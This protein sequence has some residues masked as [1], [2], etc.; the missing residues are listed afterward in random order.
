MARTEQERRAQ[1]E[2]LASKL[3]AS[4]LSASDQRE[5]LIEAMGEL[6]GRASIAR[7]LGDIEGCKSALQRAHVVEDVYRG[8]YGELDEDTDQTVF[9]TRDQ[10]VREIY[11]RAREK[12]AE[13]TGRVPPLGGVMAPDSDEA[14]WEGQGSG[15]V[16]GGDGAARDERTDRR[17]NPGGDG[18]G[19]YSPSGGSGSGD[20]GG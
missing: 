1:A 13:R 20:I 17:W 14:P 18:G 15:E 11:A 6:E 12:I 2:E 7:Q 5:I 8:K 4:D 10:Y 9:E 3:D 19:Y 16:G